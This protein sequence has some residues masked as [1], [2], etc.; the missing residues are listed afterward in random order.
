MGPSL[1]SS[2]LP[3]INYR[4]RLPFS[5]LT[6]DRFFPCN[7]IKPCGVHGFLRPGSIIKLP[8]HVPNLKLMSWYNRFCSLALGSTH[9]KFDAWPGPKLYSSFRSLK[10][11]NEVTI[12]F[13]L[14]RSYHSMTLS[15]S[16]TVHFTTTP[17]HHYHHSQPTY[18]M[19]PISLKSNIK[20][21]NWT[22]DGRQ[23]HLLV[24]QQLILP[25]VLSG[26]SLMSTPIGRKVIPWKTKQ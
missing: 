14:K 6:P 4:Y 9:V 17:T 1:W 22:G 13:F 20:K 23:Y 12:M 24:P 21:P 3:K 2:W 15:P 16:Q 19:S 10:S 7:A 25:T 11:T 26:L 18:D 8:A 5:F